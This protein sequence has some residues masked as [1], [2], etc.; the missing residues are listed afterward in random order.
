[1]RK[2]GTVEVIEEKLA[3]NGNKYH[4]VQVG[5][6]WY[7]YWKPINFRAGQ[8]IE[9][10]ELIKGDFKN[11]DNVE[12]IANADTTSGRSAVAADSEGTNREHRIVRQN[13][14]TS[15]IALLA[16]SKG[17]GKHDPETLLA[18]VRDTAKQI[19]VLNMYGYDSPHSS[20]ANPKTAP[21]EPVKSGE[22]GADVLFSDS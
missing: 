2:Q 10:D 5:N 22:V 18:L 12:A 8:A 14:T 16:I 13:A 21:S 7:G 3:K 6:T 11:M 20:W 4:R 19:F 17:L 9:F 15:A 1:M